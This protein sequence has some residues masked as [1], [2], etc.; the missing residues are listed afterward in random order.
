MEMKFFYVYANLV[1]YRNFILRHFGLTILLLRLFKRDP[2]DYWAA[3]LLNLF[4]KRL[5]RE[6]IIF[7]MT[8]DRNINTT[9]FFVSLKRI[10]TPF[11]V[12]QKLQISQRHGWI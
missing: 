4:L 5:C 10:L 12:A 9:P 3:E 11:Q 8:L 1:E 7:K 6:N 2:W